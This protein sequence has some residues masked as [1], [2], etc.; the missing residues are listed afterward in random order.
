M[1][2][3]CD[4]CDADGLP[5]YL[6]TVAWSDPA[7]PSREKLYGRYGFEVTHD[8]P[9]ADGWTGISMTREPGGP[10]SGP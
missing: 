3:Y 4:S 1:G 6:D 2:A 7:K 9:G 10:P 5:G 8:S